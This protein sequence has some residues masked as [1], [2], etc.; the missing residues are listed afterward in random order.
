MLDSEI[1]QYLT[2]ADFLLSAARADL[3]RLIDTIK[4]SSAGYPTG[5]EG[6]TEI[7]EDGEA[8][9]YDS[10]TQSAALH[11]DPARDARKE[12]ERNVK[13][14]R[15]AAVNL[16]GL[17]QAWLFTTN[18]TPIGKNEDPGCRSCKRLTVVVKGNRVER[19]EPRRELS[20]KT[21]TREVEGEIITETVVHYSTYCEWCD[22]WFNGENQP[23]PIKVLEAHHDGKR[24]TSSLLAKL[25]VKTKSASAR[26]RRKAS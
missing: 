17:R 26:D 5:H 21:I 7:D 25:G 2:Y 19:W 20:K 3:D 13:T 22:D 15:N 12:L 11:P 1:Q 4:E 6:S 18:E 24:I 10:R 23:P 9:T 16:D 14:L 8:V